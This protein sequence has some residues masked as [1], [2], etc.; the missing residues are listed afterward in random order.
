MLLAAAAQTGW[1][2]LTPAE[3]ARTRREE[4]AR[5]AAEMIR[6]ALASSQAFCLVAEVGGR[7]VAY[8]LV[9]IHPDET[10]AI[11]TGHKLDGWVAPAFRGQ[12]LNR[13]MQEAAEAHCRRL[14]VERMTCFVAAHNAP[15]LRATDRAGFQTEKVLR[16]K[17][18]TV[19]AERT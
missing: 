9:I 11:R 15:A 4:V 6:H 12:G 2:H 1:D 16:A 7:P 18:L 3:Q 8:E 10:S 13:L 17:W 5:R 19:P 14:G